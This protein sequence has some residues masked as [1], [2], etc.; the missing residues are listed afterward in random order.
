[1]DYI[2]NIKR[3]KPQKKK[4]NKEKGKEIHRVPYP[5][6]INLQNNF[7][8]SIRDPKA[9]N[10]QRNDLSYCYKPLP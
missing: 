9:A 3:F 1:M 8:L 4:R 7:I 10:S 6:Y 2:W 5:L